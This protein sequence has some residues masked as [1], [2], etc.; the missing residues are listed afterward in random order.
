M[1][2]KVL[3][4]TKQRTLQYI[5]WSLGTLV[6]FGFLSEHPEYNKKVSYS[7]GRW[8]ISHCT[9]VVSNYIIAIQIF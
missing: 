7:M 9:F 3:A 1:L 6:L 4:V 5:G 2:D 8:N